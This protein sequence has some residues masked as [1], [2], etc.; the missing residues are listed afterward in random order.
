MSASCAIGLLFTS[1][2]LFLSLSFSGGGGMTSPDKGENGIR[3]GDTG[4]GWEVVRSEKKGTNK[5]E[6]RQWR[7]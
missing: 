1:A 5:P 2:S 4:D 6:G 3:G 7:L